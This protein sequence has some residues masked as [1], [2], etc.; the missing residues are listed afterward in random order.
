MKVGVIFPQTEIGEDPGA[1]RAF[2]QATED[3][4]YAHL[5]AYDHVLGAD[6]SHHANWRGPYTH[7]SLFHEP[8]VLFGYLAGITTTLEMVAGIIILPQRQTA[9]VAKQAAAVDVLTG[10]R[11]RL[12]VGIGWNWVEYEALGESFRNRGRRMEEQ[13]SVLRA[14]WTDE[15]VTFSGRWHRITAA[16][17]NPMPVQRPIPL[18]MGGGVEP[19]LERIGRMADGWFPQPGP[20]D[21]CR[22][23]L[24]RMHGY[25][26]DA[27]RD[28][29]EIGLEGRIN[30]RDNDPDVWCRS[31]EAWQG[32]GA[33]HVGVNTMGAGLRS[34]D[35][36]IAAIRRFAEA[37]KLG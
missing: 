10:G 16:G 34:P 20:T 2:A 27:G 23:M 26:R 30:F 28:P 15:V 4:G 5:L 18:W 36:H 1:V 22:E 31:A 29:S 32:L 3:L 19:V 21:Q 6:P 8:F 17:L 13:V 35:E 33:T 37:M 14:L 9:L 25:A 12:G 24:E 7:E 11:L